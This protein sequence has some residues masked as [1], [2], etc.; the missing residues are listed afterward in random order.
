MMMANRILVGSNTISYIIYN[1][2]ISANRK[3]L[4]DV[5][6]IRVIGW[7]HHLQCPILQI[8]LLPILMLSPLGEIAPNGNDKR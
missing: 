6:N 4:F 8:C 5:T 2:L 3:M 7:K 1:F